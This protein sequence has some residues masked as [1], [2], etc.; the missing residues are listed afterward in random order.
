MAMYF[1]VSEP[2]PSVMVVMSVTIT[3]MSPS[4]G[5]GHRHIIWYLTVMGG[6]KIVRDRGW[7]RVDTLRGFRRSRADANG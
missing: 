7:V 6:V 5:S 2:D 4:P 3:M 1:S